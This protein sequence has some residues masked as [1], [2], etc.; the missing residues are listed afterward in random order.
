M[1]L[2]CWVPGPHLT[3]NFSPGLLQEFINKFDFFYMSVFIQRV[4]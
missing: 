2:H 3:E 1:F 4:V